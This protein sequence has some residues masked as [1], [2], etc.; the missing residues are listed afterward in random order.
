MDCEGCAYEGNA[1]DEYPCCDC[2]R[3]ERSDRYE[4]AEEP[5]ER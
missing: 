2:D 3:L 5:P 1:S 4:P